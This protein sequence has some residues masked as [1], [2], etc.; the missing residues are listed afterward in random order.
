MRRHR[1]FWAAWV[2]GDAGGQPEPGHGQ[3]Y[4]LVLLMHPRDDVAFRDL[5]L[6]VHTVSKKT[7]DVQ[8]GLLYETDAAS[9]AMTFRQAQPF[10]VAPDYH[11]PQLGSRGA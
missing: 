8:V 10:Y 9:I 6:V 2:F 7:Y 1:T 11:P 5:D 4:H 3:A